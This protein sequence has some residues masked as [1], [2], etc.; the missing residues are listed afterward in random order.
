MALTS[1]YCTRRAAV[2]F[3]ANSTAFKGIPLPRV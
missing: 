2:V 1:S 3:S